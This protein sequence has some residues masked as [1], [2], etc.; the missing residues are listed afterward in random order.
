M[1]Q[2]EAK[3]KPRLLDSLDRLKKFIELNAPFPVRRG[4]R[5]GTP[6]MTRSDF[7]NA[8]RRLSHQPAEMTPT[9]ERI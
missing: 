4:P 2:K 6:A 8:L 3:L 7:E 9:S 1:K 5:S